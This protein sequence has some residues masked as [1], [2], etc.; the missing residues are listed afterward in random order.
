M[1]KKL[2]RIDR[3]VRSNHFS[4]LINSEDFTVIDGAVFDMGEFLHELIAIEEP[5]RLLDLKPV[6]MSAPTVNI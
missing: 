2:T 3:Q 5:L 6:M 1:Q 4:E